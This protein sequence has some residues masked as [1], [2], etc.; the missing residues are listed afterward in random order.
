MYNQTNKLN[1]C[2]GI[3][4]ISILFSIFVAPQ[5][6]SRLTSCQTDITKTKKKRFEG[7]TNKKAKGTI[8]VWTAVFASIISRVD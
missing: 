8:N 3:F 7:Q 4:S 5:Q 2:N 6:A 1:K